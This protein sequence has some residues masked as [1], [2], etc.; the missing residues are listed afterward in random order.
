M[1]FK[2]SKERLEGIKVDIAVV[3]CQQKTKDKNDKGVAIL[4]KSDG[5]VALDKLLGGLLTKIIKSESFSGEP[6][7]HKLVYVDG[8]IASKAVLMVGIGKLDEFTLDT[9]RKVGARV[10]SVANNIKARSIAGIIQDESV[11]K[12]VPADRI[13]ALV[14]GFIL[15]AYKFDEYKNKKDVEP[16]T[17]KNIFLIAGKDASRFEAAIAK[18][19]IIGESVNYVRKLTNLPPND[20]TPKVLANEAVK[21]AKDCG[22]GITVWGPKEIKN[23]KMGLF[24]AVAKGSTN[25][26]RFV[27]MTYKPKKK[28]KLKVALIGKGIT[29]DT[30]GYSL[31]PPRSMIGMNND[32]AGAATCIGI[33]KVL[34]TLK[35]DIEVTSYLPITDNMIDSKAEVPTSIVK[36]RNGK[37]IEITNMD[38]E[39]RLI[40]AD[41]LIFASEKKSDLMIDMAT[42][43][44]GVLYALGEIYTAVLG[45]D[46]KFVEKLLA[47]SRL[48][49]EPSWQLP[50]AKEY[51]KSLKEGPADLRNQAKTRADTIG[52]ALFLQEF[53]G[54][55]KWIHLDIAE[56]A[57]TEE[58]TLLNR[59]GATGVPM[60]TVLQFLLSV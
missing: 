37:T 5:G 24:M 44:G 6:A 47:A 30:G 2:I 16:N 45:N 38:A 43:T 46:Q 21:T 13:Q 25:E 52:A 55:T 15:G 1:E 29:F 19:R 7:S 12:L 4:L 41:T 20:L 28:A 35:P 56:S 22:L 53:V 3:L 18:G 54:D 27:Q 39:G 26:P 8:K 50:L 33:M 57:H 51:R 36:A 9:S 32:M 10:A 59:K 11:K 40:L 60:R 23:A 42:L 34:G 31:K 48:A 49:G 58:E 17:L 14:E